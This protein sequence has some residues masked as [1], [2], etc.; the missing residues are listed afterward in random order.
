[1]YELQK[2]EN[3]KLIEYQPSNKRCYIFTF[4]SFSCLNDRPMQQISRELKS[5]IRFNTAFLIFSHLLFPQIYFYNHHVEDFNSAFKFL[6]LS[7]FDF[8]VFFLKLFKCLY[9]KNLHFVFHNLIKCFAI[10]K[11]TFVTG[12][13]VYYKVK[14]KKNKE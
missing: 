7:F 8:S 14:L 4:L 13:N 3:K 10:F 5:Y 2:I 12:S 11:G 9:S 1:M 6:Y